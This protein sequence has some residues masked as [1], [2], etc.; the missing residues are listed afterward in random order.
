MQAM[1]EEND[2]LQKSIDERPAQIMPPIV[3]P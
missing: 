3:E 1:Q 2:R